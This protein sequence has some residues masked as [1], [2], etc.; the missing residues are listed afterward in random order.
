MGALEKANPRLSLLFFQNRELSFSVLLPV[1][2]LMLACLAPV[3]LDCNI[4]I[5]FPLAPSFA[6]K[7][8]PQWQNSSVPAHHSHFHCI[9]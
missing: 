7:S 1:Y 4:R 2:L 3:G 8:E 5:S 6:P 9:C